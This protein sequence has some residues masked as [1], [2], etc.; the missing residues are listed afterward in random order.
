MRFLVWFLTG[1]ACLVAGLIVVVLLT[2]VIIVQG[3]GGDDDATGTRALR[4]VG[5]LIMVGGP[6]F[7]W[8]ALP[9]FAGIA[10]LFRGPGE[11][12]N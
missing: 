8:L 7:F 4:A 1:L 10:S 3:F 11:H 2:R 5:F 12:P 9:V 6:V